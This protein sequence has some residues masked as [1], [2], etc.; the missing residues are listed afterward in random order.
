MYVFRVGII[1]C[2]R[3]LHA[4][5]VWSVPASPCVQ[6]LSEAQYLRDHFVTRIVTVTCGASP[7]SLLASR[8]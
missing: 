5:A 3:L 1:S 4:D 2:G 7:S 8:Q 6:P